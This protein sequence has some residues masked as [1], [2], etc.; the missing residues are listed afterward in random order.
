MKMPIYHTTTMPSME[1]TS[2]LSE[3]SVIAA[4]A[5]AANQLTLYS[6]AKDAHDRLVSQYNEQTKPK[7]KGFWEQF[8]DNITFRDLD[9]HVALPLTYLEEDSA[10][11]I[12][13]EGI[14][15]WPSYKI[16]SELNKA[17]ADFN[18]KH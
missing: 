5:K 2:Y 15:D 18:R 16:Q 12:I 8:K 7:K 6:Q 9:T 3:L 14:K 4:L 11:K 17:V 10:F 13:Y 1:L